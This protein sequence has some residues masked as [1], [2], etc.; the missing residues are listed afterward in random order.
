[1]PRRCQCC[2]RED[3]DDLDRA[4]LQ[5][6]ARKVAKTFQLPPSAVQRHKQAHLGKA[7]GKARELLAQAGPAA[8]EHVRAEVERS[9][10]LDE[11]YERIGRELN[12]LLEQARLAKDRKSM[13]AAITALQGQVSLKLKGAALLQQQST[14]TP[15]VA[16]PQWAQFLAV[17]VGALNPHPAA[18]AA[19]VAALAKLDA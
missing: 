10:S 16:H 15:L 12:T 5:Q 6:S 11:L 18:K 17:L 3:R 9:E 2:D 19:L 7:L 8:I 13:H 1:M 4:L 14:R